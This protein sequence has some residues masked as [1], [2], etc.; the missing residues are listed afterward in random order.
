MVCN[1]S[2]F[3]A[4]PKKAESVAGNVVAV[5]EI[6]FARCGMDIMKLRT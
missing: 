5:Q 6:D 2:T 1:N 3:E 4:K